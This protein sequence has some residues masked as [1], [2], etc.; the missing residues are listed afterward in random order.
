MISKSDKN[1]FVYKVK[2]VD[3]TKKVNGMPVTKFQITDK[4]RG[5]D[6]E[7]LTYYV[8]AFEDIAMK[9]GDLV[10]IL[11]FD[12]LVASYYEKKARIN[13]FMSAIV[14]VIGNPTTKRDKADIDNP[15]EE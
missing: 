5:T 15:Y 10:K 9:D 13:F 4:V 12:N 1:E 2:W 8:T 11:D 14:E 3:K 6:N 7:Y